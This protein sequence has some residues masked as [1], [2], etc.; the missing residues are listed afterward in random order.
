[1][2]EKSQINRD[3]M[4]DLLEGREEKVP[5]T[6]DD[7]DKLL[8]RDP[9]EIKQDSHRSFRLS[10]E[11][12]TPAPVVLG[13]EENEEAVLEQ[14]KHKSFRLSLFHK[15]KS[16]VYFSRKMHA[17][18]KFAKYQMQKLVNDDVKAQ[19]SMSSI[20]NNALKIVLH[21]FET[22]RDKSVLLKVMLKDLYRKR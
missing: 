22:K 16:T 15:K 3:V 14:D 12:H 10:T 8:Y 18:L 6:M 9:K 11:A 5:D 17:R 4:M 7:L 1:M 13:T 19:I 21:E 20:V 2:M